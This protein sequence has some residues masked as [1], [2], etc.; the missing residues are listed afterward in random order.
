MDKIKRFIDC[1]IPTETCN[2]R[3]H[4][5]YI[6]QNRKFNNKVA[7]FNYTPEY[8]AK[9]LSKERL[10]GV[11]LINFCAGG[12]TL[13]AEEVIDIIKA[14][15]VEGH[16][17]MVVTNGSLTKRFEKLAKFPKELLSHLFFKFSFHY[18]ELL[19]LKLLDTYFNNVK[20][21]QKAGASFTIE[22]TPN[23]ELEKY[24]DE[25]KKVMMEK[26]GAL[27][28]LT[29]G[30]KDSDDIPPLTEH[31]FEDYLK[32]WKTFESELMD[33][34]KEIFGKRR[35]EFC[36][37]GEWSFYLNL[38]TGDISQC[39]CG[40]KIDNVYKN[41]DRPIKFLPIGCNCKQPHC[42][43]GHA[44][45]TL[46]NIPNLITPTYDKLRNRIQTNGEEWLKPEM[47][48]IMSSK[49]VESNEEYSDTDKLRINKINRRKLRKVVVKNN[50]KSIV[51]SLLIKENEN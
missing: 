11:C 27:P 32:I 8:I 10:G 29:I 15:L 42:Y 3:C 2:F 45:L 40:I 46:G 4:Y 36:Y 30:R 24:I 16:Y 14:L 51:K 5:C 33:F 25:I 12:E 21:M 41:I 7:K 49:L 44:F 34:K 39:Y 18:Q 38:V 22:I 13:I 47:K 23:D 43:N 20:M 26:I 1:Y 28:H 6:T 9:A 48:A 37:A 17:V 35:K 50:M 19:R 31:K